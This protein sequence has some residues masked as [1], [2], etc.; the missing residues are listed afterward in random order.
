[1]NLFNKQINLSSANIRN[2][3]NDDSELETQVLFGEKIRVLKKLGEWSLCVSQTDNYKGWIKNNSF[4]CSFETTH[5][6]I[7]NRTFV[8]KESNIKSE[9][10]FYLPLGSKIYCEKTNKFL[11]EVVFGQKRTQKGFIPSQDIMTKIARYNDWVEIA[12]K[13]INIPYKWGGRDTIGLDC[14][15][16]LQLS[17]E[18]IGVKVERNT[19][20]QVKN[21]IYFDEIFFNDIGRGSIIFW[22][23]HVAIMIDKKNIIHS[24]AF[25]MK[26]NIETLKDAIKR[27]GNPIKFAKLKNQYV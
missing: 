24:N 13:L 5:R 19:S 26:V 23:G 17:L 14:S 9:V 15:A 27:I 25:H 11:C 1:M 10:L 8:Y 2:L 4:D 3:P 18:T 21:K 20:K 7:S 22:E 6:V 16:L 12:E